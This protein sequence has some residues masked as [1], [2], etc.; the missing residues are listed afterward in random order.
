MRFGFSECASF[1][2]VKKEFQPA[3]L[4]STKIEQTACY[5]E[6][7]KNGSE[8]GFYHCPPFKK[9]AVFSNFQAES[10]CRIFRFFESDLLV[11]CFEPFKSSIQML[12]ESTSKV[13]FRTFRCLLEPV[14]SSKCLQK[15]LLFWQPKSDHTVGSHTQLPF[16]HVARRRYRACVS[17]PNTPCLNSPLRRVLKKPY[18]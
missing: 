18:F 8:S 11:E 6:I 9:T 13:L 12:L 16:T 15:C 10:S 7:G 14:R 5:T 1:K 2:L 3:N 4:V 17:A